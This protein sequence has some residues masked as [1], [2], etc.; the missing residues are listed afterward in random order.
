MSNELDQFKKA[1]LAF[2][3]G[4]AAA[5]KSRYVKPPRAKIIPER[6]LKYKFA[7][8]LAAD[9]KPEKDMRYFVI[10]DGTFIAGDFIEAFITGHNLHVKRLFISTLSMSLENADSLKNLLAGDF[11]D[12]LSLIVSDYFYSHE[13]NGLIPYLY[14][15]LDSEAGKFQLAV[16]GTHCKIALIETHCGLKIV[17]HGSAN[18]RSSSNTE[19]IAIEED[20][21]LFEFNAGIMTGIIETYSTI[22]KTVRYNELWQ[23][24]QKSPKEGR[25]LNSSKQRKRP[26]SAGPDF[27][28]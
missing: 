16:A 3:R 24:G 27:A 25:A 7:Q 23:A 9:I 26:P 10:I 12:E 21:E 1:P 4:T 2:R 11:V 28:G 8:E 19:Q 6:M 13:R 20:A 15:E 17:L 5:S 14:Q 22:K 18:L